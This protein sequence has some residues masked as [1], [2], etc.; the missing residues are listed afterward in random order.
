[1]GNVLGMAVLIFGVISLA[2]FLSN[3]RARGL[4]LGA[5][6]SSILGIALIL[7]VTGLA[8]YASP[9]LG[10]AYLDGHVTFPGFD[11]EHGARGLV[12]DILATPAKEVFVLVFLLYTAGFVLF[13]AA[14]WR[15]GAI[16]RRAG[17]PLVLHA[18]L[19]SSFIRPQPTWSSIL[20]RYFSSSRVA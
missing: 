8:A 17:L 1:M 13:G 11:G 14:L 4:T 20:G 16:R 6:V 18:P 3:T 10:R 19:F 9:A 2:A 15:S 5:M 12:V 7:S